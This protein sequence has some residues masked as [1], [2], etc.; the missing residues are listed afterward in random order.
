MYLKFWG[1]SDAQGVPRM[2][3]Q[4][5][6]C[7][8]SSPMNIRKRP[9]LA[10]GHGKNKVLIDVA[11]DFHSQFR[12][13]GEL[14]PPT[15]LLVTH[16]HYDHI[17][18]LGDFADLCLWNDVHAQIISPPDVIDDLLSRYPYLGKRKCLT[19]V[20]SVQWDAG[21]WKVRFH[22]VNHGQNG[23]SYGLL[24]EKSL[25]RWAYISDSFDMT[26]EQLRS[27]RN[28]EL[29]VLGASL[30]DE[31]AENRATR[32]VYDVGEAVNIGRT[33][34]AKRL[35][36]THLS[37]DIDATERAKYLPSYAIFAHDGLELEI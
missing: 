24:F 26:L 4:C 36:L 15:T 35:V 18:G 21:G 22:K 14:E 34:E 29:L 27:F 13:Y 16:A 8:G 5:S 20:P 7:T 37:H 1:T 19:F 25:Q 30:W 10:F 23:V 6:V 12:Q 11:P 32:S 17:G 31:Q 3:C 2:M 9:S 28:C 33:L